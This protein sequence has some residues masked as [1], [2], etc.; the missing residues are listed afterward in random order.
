[1]II[2]EEEGV[3]ELA[4]KKTQVL[5]KLDEQI[6][7]LRLS[8]R[9]EIPVK[10]K[11]IKELQM[12]IIL[13]LKSDNSDTQ[14]D[15]QSLI[16]DRKTLNIHKALLQTNSHVENLELEVESPSKKLS[17]RMMSID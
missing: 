12:D 15:N 11:S 9:Q 2:A 4:Y 8:I 14:S 10:L 16:H 7:S 5:Q 6:S 3:N 17:R 13:E 1:M